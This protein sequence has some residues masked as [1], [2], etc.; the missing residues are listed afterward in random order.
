[1][2]LDVE[3]D[4]LVVDNQ[5]VQVDWTLPIDSIG[6]EQE[7]IEAEPLTHTMVI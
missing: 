1:M 2:R 4:L 6:T 5:S 3:D 7:D